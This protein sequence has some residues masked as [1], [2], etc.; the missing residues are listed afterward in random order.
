ML[1]M[2]SDAIK[3]V[4]ASV[5]FRD[6]KAYMQ[7]TSNVIDQEKMA[8]IL[9]EVVG[10]QSVSY[11]HL[12]SRYNQGICPDTSCPHACLVYRGK[13]NLSNPHL[14]FH[15]RYSLFS[16]KNPKCCIR[17]PWWNRHLPA[18]LP[19][20]RHF[21]PLRWSYLPHHLSLIHI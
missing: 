1:R 10:N 19:K 21:L 8:V 15:C 11:T 17:R 4:Y 7:A 13:T 3:G 6:S 14:A 16:A 5:Y 18:P 20:N 12:R 9:Q 2:V